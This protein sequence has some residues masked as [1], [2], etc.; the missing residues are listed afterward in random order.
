MHLKSTH[1][2]LG[3]VK[4]GIKKRAIEEKMRII[5]FSGVFGL[6]QL[7]IMHGVR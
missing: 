1:F 3:G 2:L 6:G 7:S 4:G 5:V